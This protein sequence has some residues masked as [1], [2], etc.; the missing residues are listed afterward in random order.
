MA[1]E[2]EKGVAFD[3]PG[4]EGAMAPRARPIDFA[5]LNRQTMGD[6]T[7]EQEVLALFIHQA[8]SVCEQ[9]AHAGHEGR[10]RL[11]H[12]LK[13]AAKGVGAFPI[14]DCLAELESR[15]DHEALLRQLKRLVAEAA[16]VVASI[17]R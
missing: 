15:P 2:T 9:I 14:A 11:A 4:G 3:R 5:H 1:F 13:G 8:N 7:L 10:L 12:T 16:E 6:R 17:S